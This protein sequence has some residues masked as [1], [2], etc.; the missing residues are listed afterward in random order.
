MDTSSPRAVGTD[1]KGNSHTIYQTRY[2]RY[3]DKRAFDKGYDGIKWDCKEKEETDA[4]KEAKGI[5]VE[6]VD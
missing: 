1:I 6:R 4:G 5:C 2:S 3:G